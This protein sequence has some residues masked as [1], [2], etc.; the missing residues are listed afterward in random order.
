MFAVLLASVGQ[1]AIQLA[2]LYSLRVITTCG[3]KNVDLVKH[4]GATVALDYRSP[5]I[6]EELRAAAPELAHV[7]DT[8][9]NTT[10]SETASKAV[11]TPG[12]LCTVRPGKANT[13]KVATGVEIT[14]VL[15][16]TAFFRDHSY[17]KY[18]WPVSIATP[19]RAHCQRKTNKFSIGIRRRPQALK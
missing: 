14:D 9:G 8:I 13:E 16:W 2:A 5:N 15:V 19:L 18:H 1:Y 17:G 10:S 6:V 11:R 3:P 12:R 4:L 7:F